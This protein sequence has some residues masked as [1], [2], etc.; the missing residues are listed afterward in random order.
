MVLAQHEQFRLEVTSTP[1]RQT[2]AEGAFLWTYQFAVVHEN[3]PTEALA[4]ASCVPDSA[5]FH[6]T[7]ANRVA[8]FGAKFS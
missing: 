3:A 8:Q 5:E 2:D 1:S 7:L 6:A 4:R